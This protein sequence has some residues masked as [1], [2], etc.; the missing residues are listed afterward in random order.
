[1][2]AEQFWKRFETSI[3]TCGGSGRSSA[4]GR[5]SAYWRAL[6]ENTA[7]QPRLAKY[8]ERSKKQLRFLPTIGAAICLELLFFVFAVAARK[9]ASDVR[10]ICIF[11][12]CG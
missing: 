4:G 10:A 3:T 1:M 11:A 6:G 12:P 9:A 7:G 8:R 2:A 5:K